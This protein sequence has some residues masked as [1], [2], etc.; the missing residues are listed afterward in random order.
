MSSKDLVIK[1]GQ[2]KDMIRELKGEIR[3]LAR[4]VKT[5]RWQRKQY[6]YQLLLDILP[7]G[8]AILT[9]DYAEN[10]F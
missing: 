10:C 7:S 9:V 8:E 3:N 1:S 5:A 6:M 2:L 4:H